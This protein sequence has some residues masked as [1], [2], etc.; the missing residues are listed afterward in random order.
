M[1]EAKKPIFLPPQVLVHISFIL[2]SQQT[3]TCSKP[4]IETL[5]KGRRFGVF[6]VNFEHISHLFLMFVLL[7]LSMHLFAKMKKCNFKIRLNL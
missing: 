2:I 7:I 5:K 3:F 4:T 1:I 6:I